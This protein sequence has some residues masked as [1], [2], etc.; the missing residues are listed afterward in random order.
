M[1]TYLSRGIKDII[2]EFPAVA[3]ILDE[4]GIGCGPCDVGICQL[5]DVVKLH[6]LPDD[7]EREMM[8]RIEKTIYPDRE[9]RKKVSA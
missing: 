1:E 6:R 9:I 8:G 5:K 4:Y 2:T 7:R 3:G